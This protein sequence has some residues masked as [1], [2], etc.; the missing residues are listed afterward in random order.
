M[1]SRV[2]S[3]WAARLGANVALLVKEIVFGVVV[4]VVSQQRE[5]CLEADV[6]EDMKS[7]SFCSI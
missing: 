3:L 5:E 4:F 6:T 2:Y 7:F 1:P